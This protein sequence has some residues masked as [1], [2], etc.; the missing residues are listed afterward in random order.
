MTESEDDARKIIEDE[1][2]RQNKR[3]YFLK[4]QGGWLFFTNVPNL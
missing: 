3:Y 2:E 1:Y 4:L